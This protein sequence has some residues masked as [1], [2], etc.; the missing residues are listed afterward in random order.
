V[1]TARFF[2]VDISIAS[3]VIKKT[4]VEMT[5]NR[6]TARVLIPDRKMFILTCR[7]SAHPKVR[8]ATAFQDL[9]ISF[10]WHKDL[11]LLHLIEMFLGIH[12]AVRY[13]F[14]HFFL[15]LQKVC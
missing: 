9:I 11:C 2:F 3:A 8:L 5:W 15:L 1:K 13:I 4:T 7:F 6:F 14:S 10:R 12:V